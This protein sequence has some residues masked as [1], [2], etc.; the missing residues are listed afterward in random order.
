MSTTTCWAEVFAAPSATLMC[1]GLCCLQGTRWAIF[2]LSRWGRWRSQESF[3]FKGRPKIA[4]RVVERHRS[5][6]GFNM[7][8][9]KAGRSVNQCCIYTLWAERYTACIWVGVPI[10][11]KCAGGGKSDHPAASL[12][13]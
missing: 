9:T 10:T 5:I 2:D 7:S 11:V 12:H 8:V 3:Y 13:L 1:V 6:G 4:G